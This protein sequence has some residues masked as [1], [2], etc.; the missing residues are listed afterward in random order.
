MFVTITEQNCGCENFKE[1]RVAFGDWNNCQLKCPFCFTSEQ[2]PSSQA[3]SALINADLNN[4]KIIRFTGG[5]PLLHQS[6]IQGMTS[7][8]SEIESHALPNLDLIIIQTNAIA[9]AERDIGGLFNFSL[10][11]LFEVS[12][13]GTN[14]KEYQYLTY[15]A[16]I[17]YA[18]AERIMDKQLEGY[19][20]ISSYCSS[21]GNMSILARLGIFHSSIK[22]PK[23]AFVSPDTKE[24]MFNPE[25]WD[26]QFYSLFDNQR[27]KWENVYSRK[28]VVE[29]LKTQG[30]G[31]PPMGRRYRRIIDG[32]ITM[33]ILEEGERSLPEIY[34]RY[35]LYQKGNEIYWRAS[36]RLRQH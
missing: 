27:K 5:E 17:D 19:Q 29:K 9:V 22:R 24:L 13:K 34:Q 8:L 11:I 18:R 23:F 6:Q 30:D 15:T 32:L 7:V 21:K 4:I 3:L 35:Y 14:V 25:K 28:L 31:T 12:F 1:L 33:G 16:P 36:N 26:E 10:P 2:R 20:A